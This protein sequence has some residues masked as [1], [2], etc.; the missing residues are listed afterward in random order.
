MTTIDPWALTADGLSFGTFAHSIEVVR[1]MESLPA[2]RGRSQQAYARHGDVPSFNSY[3]SA[4]TLPLL[5]TIGRWDDDG[6]DG[7][8]GHAGG[9]LGQLR[10]NWDQM[11]TILGKRHGFIDLRRFIPQEP[12][13]PEDPVVTLELQGDAVVNRPV[14]VSGSVGVWKALV[15]F[16]LPYPFWHELPEVERAAATSHSFTTGGTAPI[17][18]MVFTFSGDGTLSYG[19]VD[20]TVEGSSG[21]VTVDV[22]QRKAFQGGNVDMSVLRLEDAADNWMEWPAQTAI[23]LTSTVSVAVDYFNARH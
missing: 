11:A 23:S 17:N 14:V 16:V 15:E 2:R 22:G 4:K 21:A 9:Q 18:D 20:I 1:G 8:T 6:V 12:V 13:D 10:D 3:F 19:A 7:L 5:I